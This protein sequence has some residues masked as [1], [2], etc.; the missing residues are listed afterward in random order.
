ME[1]VNPNNKDIITSIFINL[2]FPNLVKLATVCKTW[3]K[4]V[5]V[6]KQI[7]F[8][9]I[10]NW[11]NRRQCWANELWELANI[12]QP[13][14]YS[15]FLS[16]IFGNYAHGIYFQFCAWMLRVTITI[17]NPDIYPSIAWNKYRKQ[18]LYF[19]IITLS[20]SYEYYLAEDILYL[21]YKG[22][23]AR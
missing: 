17:S 6:A 9:R 18:N 10:N 19:Y 12:C 2:H 5:K 1:L 20:S 4:A 7:K 22:L 11:A 3:A 14:E 8:D 15:N 13:N 21:N 23:L 16:P